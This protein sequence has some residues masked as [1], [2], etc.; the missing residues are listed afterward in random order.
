MVKRGVVSLHAKA[1]F[2]K[3]FLECISIVSEDFLLEA[4]VKGK[5]RE[6]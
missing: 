5:V 1:E 3:I 2:A 4:T 6:Q